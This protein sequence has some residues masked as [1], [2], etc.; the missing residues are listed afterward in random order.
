MGSD[1][2]FVGFWISNGGLPVWLMRNE[3]T[4]ITLCSLIFF[5]LFSFSVFAI[6]NSLQSFWAQFCQYTHMH[7]HSYPMKSPCDIFRSRIQRSEKYEIKSVRK[8][9]SMSFSVS[10]T[11]PV[12]CVFVSVSASVRVCVYVFIMKKKR[13]NMQNNREKWKGK[14][15]K[16]KTRKPNK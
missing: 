9:V 6:Y 16:K 13:R 10:L 1:G 2:H 4:N 14:G 12:F 11:V 15:T 5:V 3:T 8:A 7:T